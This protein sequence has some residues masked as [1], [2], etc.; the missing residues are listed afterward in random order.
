[1]PIFE[2]H[3]KK[4]NNIF[5]KLVS[6]QLQGIHQCPKCNSMETEKILSRFS[7]GMTAGKTSSCPA[8][9]VCE[10]AGHSCGACC[11]MHRH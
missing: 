1:M 2:Y 4:C 6:G 7:S 10:P 8:K 3:C 5:E 9:A 11:P